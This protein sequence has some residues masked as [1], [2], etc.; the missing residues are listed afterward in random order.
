M[1]YVVRGPPPFMASRKFKADGGL[2]TFTREDHNG[3]QL[4]DRA[5]R[6]LP[7]G[8]CLPPPL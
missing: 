7:N 4:F 1:H 6:F 5:D 3:M 8:F 2:V